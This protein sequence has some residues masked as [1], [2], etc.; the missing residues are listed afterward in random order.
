M[1]VSGLESLGA[2]F[3]VTG[4]WVQRGLGPYWLAGIALATVPLTFLVGLDAVSRRSAWIEVVKGLAPIFALFLGAYACRQI[5]GSRRSGPLE[6]QPVQ[7][8]FFLLGQVLALGVSVS[9]G[10]AVLILPGAL[11]SGRDF[12]PAA[13]PEGGLVEGEALQHHGRAWALPGSGFLRWHLPGLNGGPWSLEIRL[14]T[15][16]FR[17]D[18]RQPLQVE[19]VGLGTT[20]VHCIKAETPVRIAIP[21]A[22]PGGEV[23][24]RCLSP[25]VGVRAPPQGALLISETR[26]A[27]WNAWLRFW[28]LVSVQ[29]SLIMV[30][31]L[32]AS[33]LVSPPI[34]ALSALTLW[35]VGWSARFL[36]EYARLSGLPSIFEARSGAAAGEATAGGTCAR[37][38]AEI[39]GLVP[40]LRGVGL[41]DALSRGL[42][43][44][45]SLVAREAGPVLWTAMGIGLAGAMLGLWVWR[46]IPGRIPGEKGIS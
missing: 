44:P 42:I 15:V 1:T 28:G 23:T 16:Y 36:S 5:R 12:H 20:A 40:D 31:A 45:W 9:L 8:F 4:R 14:R 10:A 46:R 34:A 26:G 24:L 33:L 39:F 37:W 29:A 38:L 30:A 6:G 3:R 2:G 18:P 13:L 25:G 17:G 41:S 32:A 35:G 27:A 11:V 43:P 7:P 21:R 19:V 22:F